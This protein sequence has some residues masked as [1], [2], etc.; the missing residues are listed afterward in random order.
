[1][2]LLFKKVFHKQIKRMCIGNLISFFEVSFNNSFKVKTPLTPGNNNARL[3][4][5]LQLFDFFPHL[6][7]CCFHGPRIH[8]HGFF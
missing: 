3:L 4:F 6:F 2:R 5:F 8:F 1:M 7:Q